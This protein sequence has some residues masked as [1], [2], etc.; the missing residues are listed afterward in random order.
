MSGGAERSLYPVSPFITEGTLC[1]GSTEVNIAAGGACETS[2]G[3]CCAESESVS[4]E[5]D[6]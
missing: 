5:T 3:I 1:M 6:I 4:A 2:D